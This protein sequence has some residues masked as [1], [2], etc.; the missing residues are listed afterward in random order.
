MKCL[1][2]TIILAA[3][4]T[5]AANGAHAELMVGDKAP[6]LQT[7]QWVQGEPVPAFGTN[8]V[9]IVEFWATWCGPCVQSI[10]HL[11]QFWRAFKDKG[12][13]VIG[14]D[15]WDS[16]EAVA[17]FVKKMADNMTYRVALDD[18]SQDAGGW[19]AEHWWPRG[20]NRH[21]IPTAFIINKDGMIAWI[22]HPMGLKEQVVSNI[23]S[24]HYD[25][26]RAAAEYRSD[27]QIDQRFQELQQQLDSA[28]D[29]KKW[30]DAE[31]AMDEIDNILPRFRDSFTGQRL[32]ILL[33]QKKFEEACQF[34]ETFSEAHA[35]N[36]FWQNEL[37]WTLVTAE[38]VSDDCLRVAETI[39]GRAAQLT[40]GK[41]QEPDALDTLARAQFM[42]GKK[43]EAVATEE[44]AVNLVSDPQEKGRLESTLASYQAGV[45]PIA[46]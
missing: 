21:G 38:P 34:A 39:A 29:D 4:L 26:A 7:G 19:M 30:D 9:Y 12:V 22:G 20:V 11:N 17:P 14:Q 6:G 37:A 43:Q 44:R 24:G 25:L 36:D 18:K 13:I 40:Q 8:H 31:S 1:F 2:Q 16:D 42:L 27:W 35:T 46:K 28:I 23:V 33:G 3:A 15:V 32:K 45:L 10:P 5:F 41:K